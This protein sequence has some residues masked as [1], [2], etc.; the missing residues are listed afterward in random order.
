MS[1]PARPAPTAPRP[2]NFPAVER[3]LM[4]NG[5]RLVVAPMP[6]LPLVTVLALVDA[7]ASTDL[8]GREGLAALTARTLTEGIAGLDGAAL[9]DRFESMGTSVD[10]YADWD[11]TVMRFTV[12][13]TQLDAAFALFCDVLRAPSFPE[14]DVARRRDERLASLEQRLSEPVSYTHLRAHE[15]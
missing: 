3:A 6:R 12:T 4:A 8:R 9:T 13:P 7:G 10:A 5:V 2:Y 1:A 11:S 14:P 15:T